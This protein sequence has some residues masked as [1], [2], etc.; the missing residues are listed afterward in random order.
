[1]K[2]A[3]VPF[4][5]LFSRVVQGFL[6]GAGAILPGISGG[7]LA[8][9][10][11]VYRPL[12]QLL[13]HPIRRFASLAP[14]L[15]PV[16][17]GWVAGFFSG[18]GLLTLLFD[19]SETVACCLFIGLIAGTLPALRRDARQ[20]G[21]TPR[22]KGAMAAAFALMLFVLLFAQHGPIP[23][24]P[25]CFVS[26]L[27]CGALWGLSVIVPGMTSSS[28]L[29]AVGLLEP[30][31]DG[32]ASFDAAVLLPWL[33][34]MAAV[35]LLFSRLVGRLFER[36]FSVFSHAVLGVVLASTLSIIPLRYASAREGVLCALCAV[37]GAAAAYYSQKSHSL[38]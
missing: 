8:A 37:L 28:I 5:P 31:L 29:M 34:G 22:A 19:H 30:M 9:V 20:E 26:F 24:L 15:L 4:L 21:V 2:K 33:I 17:V 11:G 23:A 10:F 1:M 36:H 38:F 25:E 35:V 18:S 13:A 32:I 6:I 27:F 3:A 12:M 16:G 7:T 14:R